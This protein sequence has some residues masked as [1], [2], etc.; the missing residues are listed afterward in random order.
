MN[1]HAII[2]AIVMRDGPDCYLCNQG[3][4]PSDPWHVEHV[5]PR[6]A[7]G[8]DDLENLALAHASCNLTKGTRAVIRT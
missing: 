5:K 7:G 8:T 3:S 4:D 6:S 1:R 2:A